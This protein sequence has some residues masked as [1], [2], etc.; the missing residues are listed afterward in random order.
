M[1]TQTMTYLPVR[2]FRI[3]RICCGHS[4]CRCVLE[5]DPSQVEAA[6]Q[7]TKACCPLC[8]KPFTDPKVAGGAD[9]VT[10][11]AK[12]VLALDQLG[13]NVTVEFPVEQ[14]DA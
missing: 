1:Q 7:K 6:M 8:G 9:V 12:A 11:L 10:Q 4:G 3:V 14:G 2:E 13:G 5:I